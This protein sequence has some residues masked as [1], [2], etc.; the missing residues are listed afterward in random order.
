MK[1]NVGFYLLCFEGI[2]I[3]FFKF[4]ASNLLDIEQLVNDCTHCEQFVALA[5][6]NMHLNK[7][8]NNVNSCGNNNVE[9]FYDQQAETDTEINLLNETPKPIYRSRSE[10][11]KAAKLKRLKK[12]SSSSSCCLKLFC[13]CCHECASKSRCFLFLVAC[14]KT[15]KT[16]VQSWVFQRAILCAILVNTLSMGIEH[17]EQVNLE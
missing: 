11:R 14:R 2:L 12:S 8:N 1:S 13:C 16:F 7:E 4:Q 5:K 3:Y 10:R 15:L 9:G 17:H 6:S